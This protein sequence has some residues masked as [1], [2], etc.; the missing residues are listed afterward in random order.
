VAERLKGQG[1]VEVELVK[2]GF[3]ELS[4]D[5]DGQKVVET[6]RLWYPLPGGLVRRVREFLDKG[7][8]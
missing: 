1:G 6:N 5:V 4:V 3:L 7:R 2:G 8:R